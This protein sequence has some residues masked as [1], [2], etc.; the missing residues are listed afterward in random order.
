MHREACAA[1][2]RAFGWLVVLLVVV[3]FAFQGTRGIWEPDEGRYSSA[4][5]NMH[6]S[7][8]WLVP[9]LD[10]EHP[11]LTKPPLTYWAIAASIAAFGHNEWAVRLP[12]AL[13]YLG[14]GLLV[15]G[16]GRRLCPDRPWLPAVIWATSLG[17]VAASNIVSTDPIL[18]LFETAAMFAFVEAWSRDAAAGARTWYR[19]MWLGWGLAF[20]TKGPPGLL[21]LLGMVLFLAFQDRTRLR[22]LFVPEGVLLFAV[23]AFT[24]FGLI[25]AQQPDRL[26]YFLGYEVYDR[27]F[28]AEHDRN[29]EW[30]GGFEVYV[31]TLLFGTMPWS[32][33]AVVA[34]GGP[35]AAW[36][37]ARER[38]GVRRRDDLLLAWW[39]LLPLAVFFLARSRLHLYVLPLFVPL[40]VVM[41]RSLARWPK[42]T[43]RRLAAVVATAALA[44]VG[45]KALLGYWPHDRDARAFAAQLEQLVDPHSIEE[46]VFVGMR[47]FYGLNIYIDRRIEGIDLDRTVFPYAK[48]VAREDVCEELAERERAVYGAGPTEV[49][50]FL[51][52]ARRCGGK[53]EYVGKVYADGHDI[54]LYLMPPVPPAPPPGGDSG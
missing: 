32:V 46:V 17:P 40:S 54:A 44:L 30:Y 39:L 19:V 13:A 7:G 23:V 18:A 6:E 52:E 51:A 8:D 14:T 11:H 37:R 36:R 24:W 5:V 53:P 33:L 31:P 3:G 1:A 42:A 22:Q 50:E 25:I 29:S 16:F 10:G 15:F 35:A 45:L 21:P 41:A 28:T 9:T 4:A 27:V 49:V 20:M 38:L 47:P 48:Y 2:P 34:A 43:D 12:S 26:Q